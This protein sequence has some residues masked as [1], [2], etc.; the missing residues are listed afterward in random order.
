MII[1]VI[2]LISLLSV[3]FSNNIVIKERTI[4]DSLP[5]NMLI[6]KKIFWGENGLL[7]D[8]FADP[9]SRIKELEI[10]RNMLQLHQKL[11]LF[12]LGC[13]AYQYHIGNKMSN[14]HEYG[15]LKDLHMKL[16]YTTFGTYMGSASLSI[17]APPGM[18]YSKKRFTSN[19]LH[20]YLAIIHFTGMAIQPWL[21]YKTSVAGLEERE[22]DRENLLQ[23]HETVG[24]ITLTAYSLAFLTT[25]F[26]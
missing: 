13:M 25:L 17:L 24:G 9:K 14:P 12:T 1:R 10:R 18:K 5:K 6:V 4:T 2:S 22:E 15:E 19:K 16:G 23:M 11:A 21:G 3:I 8:S 20:R 7:R 26:K